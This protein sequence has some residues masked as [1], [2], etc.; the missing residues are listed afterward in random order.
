MEYV[1]NTKGNMF[2]NNTLNMFISYIKKYNP[3]FKTS[4]H[5]D[6]PSVIGITLMSPEIKRE[7]IYL[8]QSN[9]LLLENVLTKIEGKTPHEAMYNIFNL[10]SE[11]KSIAKAI[12][13]LHII[14][15]QWRSRELQSLTV[16]NLI[17]IFNKQHVSVKLKKR[18]NPIQ[19]VGNLKVIQ[20]YLNIQ[21]LLIYETLG[22]CP[23]DYDLYSPDIA[24]E[25]L[26][27]VPL[28]TLNQYISKSISKKKKM[29]YRFG[30]QALRSLAIS[31][32]LNTLTMDQTSQVV[33]HKKTDT[34]KHYN[35]QSAAVNNIN[36]FF[37]LI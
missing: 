34:L 7:T 26:V 37:N 36:S 8:V 35:N 20:R 33:R 23:K 11:K 6:E 22:K 3:N 4:L 25:Y 31:D 24:N 28:S 29:R 18:T 9:L 19:V 27:K 5:G 2:S 32:L 14:T 13:I 10:E 21:L 17:E 15:F 30:V 16:N 1:N 12:A